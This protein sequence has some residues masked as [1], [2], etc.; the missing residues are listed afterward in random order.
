MNKYKRKC[1]NDQRKKF[2][3]LNTRRERLSAL[4]HR[5][6]CLH[7]PVFI[8]RELF[9]MHMRTVTSSI[10]SASS[11]TISVY[12]C[13]HFALRMQFSFSFS[14]LQSQ[15]HVFFYCATVVL[16]LFCCA[17]I[18]IHTPNGVQ[19]SWDHKDFTSSTIYAISSSSSSSNVNHRCN[20]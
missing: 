1:Y 15:E 8:R 16:S 17:H 4:L 6:P 20:V 7:A 10:V 13:M 9:I 18:S 11:V 19:R 2:C 14:F 3:E 12:L 5:Y